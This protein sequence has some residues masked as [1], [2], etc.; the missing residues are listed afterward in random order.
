MDDFTDSWRATGDQKGARS[1]FIGAQHVEV[2][3]EVER[4]PFGHRKT[5]ISELNRRGENVIHFLAPEPIEQ[6]L[7]SIDS[8]GNGCGLDPIRRH[9][10]K[11]HPVQ[12]FYRLARWRP[13]ASIQAVE[14]A[15][16]RIVDD[17]EEIAA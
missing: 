7:P 1:R 6:L 2:V 11:S 3:C 15:A 5:A 12:T 10:L 4:N 13:P 14:L 9:L 17:R 16:L 8:P